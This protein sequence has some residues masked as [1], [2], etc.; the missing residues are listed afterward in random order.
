MTKEDIARVCHEANRALC[1]TH[2]DLSQ[3]SWDD[4]PE[5]QRSSAIVGVQYVFDNPSAGPE[6][7]HN[8]WMQQKVNE[9]WVYGPIKDAVNKV[10]PCLVPYEQLPEHQKKKDMLFRAIVDALK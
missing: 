4:A 2:G 9:G 7:Q 6:D 8:C 3:V 1:L 5:W 10:H